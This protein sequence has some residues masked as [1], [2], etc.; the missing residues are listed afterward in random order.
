[1]PSDQAATCDDLARDLAR[2]AVLRREIA[3]EQTAG[4]TSDLGNV[5]MSTAVSPVLGATDAL[6]T[7]AGSSARNRRYDRAA[8]AADARIATL[9]GERSRRGCEQPEAER[10]LMAALAGSPT[11]PARARGIRGVAASAFAKAQRD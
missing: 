1:M 4:N 2:V 10:V 9:L 3:R 7:A 11:D 8:D 5:A 6:I